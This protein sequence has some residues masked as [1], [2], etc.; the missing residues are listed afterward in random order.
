MRIWSIATLLILTS[1]LVSCGSGSGGSGDIASHGP[2]DSDGNYIEAWADRR[3]RWAGRKKTT[4][5]K[6]QKS[7]SK[8]KTRIAKVKPKAKPAPRIVAS[9]VVEKK[10]ST[11]VSRPKPKPVAKP[12]PKIQLKSKPRPRPKAKPKSKPKPKPLR[13]HRVKKGDTL[14]GLS[15][16]YG[17]TVS[18][19]Q[20]MNG[21]KGTNIRDG[22]ILKIPN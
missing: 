17:T 9:R 4:T 2:F 5:K 10:R 14:Y 7:E 11:T 22:S 3:P 13:T 1:F 12:K 18:A 15:R 16:R 8:P 6:V 20:R 19:I 21:I